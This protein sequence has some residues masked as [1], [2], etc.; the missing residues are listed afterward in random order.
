MLELA[1]QGVVRFEDAGKD[2]GSRAVNARRLQVPRDLTPWE[3]V[4]LN[5]AFQKEDPPGVVRAEHAWAGLRAAA[6]S[7]DAAVRAHLARTRE[8]AT[9][10][11]KQ[12]RPLHMI[13]GICGALTLPAL[14]LVPLQW[15]GLGPA[16][17]AIPLAFVIIAATALI[18]A[19]TLVRAGFRDHP[20]TAA[21]RGFAHHL[22]LMSKNP[23]GLDATRFHAWLP[24]AIA[25]GHGP[26]WVSA[27]KRLHLQPPAWFQGK[28]DD[29]ADIAALATLLARM[30][31]SQHVHAA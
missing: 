12:G 26:G 4:V 14:V 22:K 17:M 21:W 13:A 1:D 7:F 3:Q 20:R 29:P 24:Y 30:S 11:D 18:A 16:S 28:P 15:S 25:L 6:K 31:D 2:W 23:A 9:Q 27:A 5:A 19:T 8:I 10:R